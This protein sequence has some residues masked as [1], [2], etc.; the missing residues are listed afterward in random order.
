VALT[1]TLKC[2]IRSEDLTQFRADCGKHGFVI[3]REDRKV[4]GSIFRVDVPDKLA[5][6]FADWV[7]ANDGEMR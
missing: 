6:T 1:R 4:N 5:D 7:R 3:V 2:A